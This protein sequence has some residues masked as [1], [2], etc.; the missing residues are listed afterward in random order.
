M[1]VYMFIILSI[2]N[3]GN[4]SMLLISNENHIPLVPKR[5]RNICFF[6]IACS[7]IIG[8]AEKNKYASCMCRGT[9][10][11]CFNCLTYFLLD[12]LSF[13]IMTVHAVFEL[14]CLHF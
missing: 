4:S 9:F 11:F 3:L 12:S 7:L 2:G 8:A 10:R 14:H 13:D 6:S 5:A 1:N